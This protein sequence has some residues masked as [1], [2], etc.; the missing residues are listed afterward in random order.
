MSQ[1][2]SQTKEIGGHKFEVFMLPPLDANDI[3]I[4]IGKAIAPAIGKAANALGAAADADLLDLDV[5]N[6]QISAGIAALAEQITKEK[7]RDLI[8][9]MASVSHCDGTPLPKTMEVV[10]RGDL[11]LLYRWLWFALEVNFK[12]F[13]DWLGGAIKGFTGLTRAAQSRNTSKG[14]GQ[15]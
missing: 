2:D 4:D 10:F 6:P 3:L 5:D 12:N 14:S 9:K 15:S 1:L 11:P 8:R 7:M 13:T